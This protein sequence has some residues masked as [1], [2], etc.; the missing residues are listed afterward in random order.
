[1]ST[2]TI[3]AM[4]LDGINGDNVD[5]MIHEIDAAMRRFPWLEMILC[6][7][8]NACGTSPASAVPMP[9]PREARFQ[10]VARRHGIWLIPG[11]MF[12]R[13]GE[14]V[15]NTAPVISPDGEV[16]ARYRKQFP[17][18]PYEKDVS[19]GGHLTVFEIPGIG[20]FGLSICYD[21]WFPETIRALVWEGAE[22]ILHPTLT[23]TI[24][25]SAE[26]AMVRAHA[27]MNQCYF[28]DVNLA[29]PL[30]VGESC[31]AGPGGEV[32]YQAQKV[33]EIIPIKLDLDY[34]HDVRKY[35]WHNLGQPLK[36]F[37]D[38]R[39]RYPQYGEGQTSGWLEALGDLRMP[40]RGG[41]G[42]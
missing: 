29:G 7:E 24:D 25:R 18:Y 41:R 6:P 14:H 38:S 26:I 30:G 40:D 9:G 34:L 15:Y 39:I 32:V 36:S 13:S 16:I 1:M 10:A 28:V 11:S 19:P 8:L 17:F 20:R 3:A 22:I 31:I 27:A 5:A 4:Q 37:R 42:Q 35:G 21:M 23:T 2:F 12:E 33:R